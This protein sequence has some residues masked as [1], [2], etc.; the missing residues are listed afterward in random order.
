MMVDND[1]EQFTLWKANPST[2]SN[3]V[4]MPP[5]DCINASATAA[6]PS[7]TSTSSAKPT[8]TPILPAAINHAVVP[9][10]TIAGAVIGGI[11]GIALFFT[12]FLFLR[13]KR[14]N[15]HSGDVNST[16]KDFRPV[17]PIL[18]KPELAVNMP[19]PQEMPLIQDTGY[20]LAPYEMSAERAHSE[21]PTNVFAASMHEMPDA[22]TPRPRDY[23]LPG[24][25]SSPRRLRNDSTTATNVF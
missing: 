4:A 1:R 6:A 21:L 13:K 12:A 5:P 7:Q 16:E 14:S 3:L 22:A 11:A 20:G 10:G 15:I 2:S 23:E 8:T 25:P 19:P 18:Y 17:S 9:K 24:L